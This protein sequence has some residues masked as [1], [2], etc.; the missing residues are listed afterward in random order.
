MSTRKRALRP[1]LR[2]RRRRRLQPILENLENRL[3]LSSLPSTMLP[4]YIIYHPPGSGPGQNGG[5]SVPDQSSTPP[6]SAYGPLQLQTAYGANNIFFGATHGDG[7]G[8]TIAV[9]DAYDNPG[10]VDSTDSNFS[11]SDLALFDK[12]YGLPNPPSFIK[13]NQDGSSNPADLP[14]PDPMHQWGPEEALDIEY[15]HAMAPKANIVVV[16]TNFDYNNLN[17]SFGDLFTGAS[18]A[19]TLASVVS[20]SFGYP[21]SF[22][23][24]AGESNGDSFFAGHPGVTFVASTGDSG[25]PWRISRLLARRRDGRRHVVV[26]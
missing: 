3:V 23:G 2:S 10:F 11:T 5:Q 8:E 15:A 9:V 24:S 14:G 17:Q 22:F 12:Q 16:E 20:M 19:A 18:T 6:S 21:E 25:A 26:P 1:C 4:T 7:L 13:V